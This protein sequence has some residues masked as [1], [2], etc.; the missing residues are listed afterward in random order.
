MDAASWSSI[1]VF[2][3]TFLA[4]ICMWIANS[5]IATDRCV[6]VFSYIEQAFND[7]A[8]MADLITCVHS[9]LTKLPLRQHL[10]IKI[11]LVK[12]IS[13]DF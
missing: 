4:D 12:V 2:S 9:S 8:D 5:R 13:Q 11:S 6:C 3:L 7:N 1:C 10:A